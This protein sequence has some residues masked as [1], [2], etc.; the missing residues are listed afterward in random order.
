[1]RL[2]FRHILTLLLVLLAITGTT[3]KGAPR[4]KKF[5]GGKCYIYRLTLSDKN[6]STYSLSHPGLFLSRKSVER[7]KRQHLPLD[8]TDLPVCTHYIKQLRKT[9]TEILGTSR[10]NNTVLIRTTDTAKISQLAALPFVKSTK[11]VY[12]SPDSITA[13]L[14]PPKV[15][16]S[17]N[18]W[19]SISTSYH[20]QGKDQ[21]SIHGGQR[22]HNAGY[23]GKGKT[24]AILDGGFLNADKIPTF[25]QTRIIGAKDFV[26]P[27]SPSVYYVG[28]HGTK[29]LSTM[30][31][32]CPGVF[33]G[34]A[35]E[36]AYW[37][38]RCEDTQTEQEVEE[39]YWAMA[40]EFADSAGVDIINSSLG[41]STYDNSCGSHERWELDGHST[42]ISHTASMLADKGIV[43]INS[44]GNDG[45]R[46]WKKLTFPA[47]ADNCL[48]VGA[49]SPQRTVA[50][51]SAVGPTQ[52]G[53]V[54]PDVMSIGS[55]ATV[56][57]ARGTIVREM[58]TSFA[59]PTLCGLVAC[60]WQA[61]PDKTAR[62][63]IEIVRS[64]GD[65][66][67]H[68]DNVQGYGIPDMWRAFMI[69]RMQQ[70]TVQQQ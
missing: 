54:K 28:E 39:D 35:P 65:N 58:G 60:L 7:R 19:D 31:A 68:P 63:I 70:T 62:E 66:R 20:A 21:I 30:A 50:P 23:K 32:H 5:P 22:L 41:Y 4:K 43:L 13:L 47:D 1:M 53:R 40:A 36:A 61:L 11:R 3:A 45:M 10:W 16:K 34:T 29:V 52:D 56:L 49:V 14:A 25:Q 48:T 17:F 44:A 9:D 33:V 42:L 2:A 24:I 38:L 8:S 55:E 27:A 59:S 67:Q 64:V 15:H 46:A 69:G 37:L 6:G 12:T 51:F 26:Y 18:S 57:S